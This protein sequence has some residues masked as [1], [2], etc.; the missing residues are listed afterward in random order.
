MRDRVEGDF[1]ACRRPRH[2]KF[3]TS[4]AIL[5]QI[6]LRSPVKL[7]KKYGDRLKEIF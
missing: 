3:K 2:A 7:A 6:S 1:L 4:V 5:A